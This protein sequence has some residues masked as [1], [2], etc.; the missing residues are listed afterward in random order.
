MV[1]FERIQGFLLLP[2]L[3]QQQA[4]DMD[5]ALLRE[6]PEL[7]ISMKNASFSWSSNSPLGSKK[8]PVED[9]SS[10]KTA[11]LH[12]SD[13]AESEVNVDSVILRKMNVKIK[14]GQL[15]FIVGPVGG[16][17]SSFA[18]AILGEMIKTDG[19]YAVDKSKTVAYATQNPWIINGTIRENILFGKNYDE[20][21]FNQVIE[22]CA[23][24]HDLTLFSNGDLTPI[25]ERG[26]NL[27]G[28]QKARLSLA[29]AVY[30]QADLYST[31]PF[32]LS[33]MV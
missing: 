24:K 14:Q 21:W 5:V 10:Q 28:G 25:G 30:S 8:I 27:S 31:L 2:D 32:S 13:T 1:S 3:D 11:P 4:K 22:V 33:L 15:V 9:A 18:N 17:K 26:V 20:E 7:V 12:E 16:G 29:R 6:E 19:T 23:L